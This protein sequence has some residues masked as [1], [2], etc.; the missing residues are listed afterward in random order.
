MQ[1]A[2]RQ[3]TA[4]VAQALLRDGT[5]AGEWVLDPR[6]SS[7]RLKTKVLGLI[8]VR[9]IFREVTGEGTIYPDGRVSGTVTVAAA[10]VDTKNTRRDK[11]LRSA[12]FFD[13]ANKPSITFTADGVQLTG[14]GVTVTGALTVRD[15]TRPLSFDVAT[16]VQGEG[17]I[18]LDA[19]VSINRAAFGLTWNQM[20]M[21]SMNST[22]A[23]HVVFTRR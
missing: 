1:A 19:E 16:S 2:P 23:I 17:E 22:L 11:H 21:T 14:Q 5:L 3:M 12:D 9:G 13:S 18:W 20:G 4:P 6:K 7:I 8:P 10:S 15:A